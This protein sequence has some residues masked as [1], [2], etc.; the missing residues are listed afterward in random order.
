MSNFETIVLDGFDDAIVGI[1]DSTSDITHNGHHG[2][3]LVYDIE[4]MIKILKNR[5]GME[6]SEAIKYLD[7]NILNADMGEGQ[8]IFIESCSPEVALDFLNSGVL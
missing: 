7:L 6:L 4:K 1:Y 5:D 8:P 3:K 2:R